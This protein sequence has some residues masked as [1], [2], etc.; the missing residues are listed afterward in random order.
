MVNLQ[1]SELE[2]KQIFNFVGYQ[3]NL[4]HGQVLPTQSRWESLLHKVSLLLSKPSCWVKSLMSL[5]GSLIATE[6]QVPHIRV[7]MRPIQWHL[8]N[9][10]RILE[11]LKKEIPIPRSLHHHLLWWTQEANVLSGQPLGHDLQVFTDTL[12]KGWG[13]HLG[14][15]TASGSWSIQES[16]LHIKFLKLKAALLALKRFEHVVRRQVV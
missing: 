16:H 8:K 10:W 6:K 11:S 1:K 7:R 4:L 9:H 14:D 12:N 2:P 5:I 3:C 15:F 13:A